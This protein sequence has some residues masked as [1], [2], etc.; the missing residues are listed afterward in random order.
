MPRARVALGLAGCL[1]AASV[2][3][4]ARAQAPPPRTV[5]AV[6]AVPAPV[7]DGRLDDPV[8]AGAEP[9]GGFL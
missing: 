1:L 3:A 7:I 4:T 5:M 8:W 2:P 6:R 9:A